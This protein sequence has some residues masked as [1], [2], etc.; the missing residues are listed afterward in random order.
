MIA[1]RQILLEENQ[2]Y[3]DEVS[4]ALGGQG[5]SKDDDQSENEF[6]VRMEEP[7]VILAATSVDSNDFPVAET[8][9]KRSVDT[10]E[11]DLKVNKKVRRDSEHQPYS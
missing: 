3:N 10:L 9:P 1:E 11:S 7:E 6:D 4:D 5:D 8:A 2:E